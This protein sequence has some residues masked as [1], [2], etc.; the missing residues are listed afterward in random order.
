TLELFHALHGYEITIVTL[1]PERE[2]AP[3]GDYF[4]LLEPLVLFAR[5][6]E[7][8][9]MKSHRRRAAW[10]QKRAQARATGAPIIKACPNWLEPDGEVGFRVIE[11]RAAIVR[12]VFRLCIEG[13]GLY[14]LVGRLVED[15]VPCFGS[16]GRWNTRYLHD[17]L[18]GPAAAG[19]FQPRK[20]VDG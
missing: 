12:Q 18:T 20:L 15:E 13:M 11:E 16:S 4:S 2:Y 1:A 14:R 10:D 7:E 5:S 3:G 17:V 8:S 19:G 6:H 9:V